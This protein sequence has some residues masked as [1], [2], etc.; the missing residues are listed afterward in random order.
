MHHYFFLVLISPVFLHGLL[1]YGHLLHGC[2]CQSRMISLLGTH[3][4]LSEEVRVADVPMFGPSLFK[5][6]HSS[7]ALLGP[8]DTFIDGRWKIFE[9]MEDGS[10]FAQRAYRV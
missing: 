10:Q 7:I 1:A 3:G 8:I 2:P 4:I 9:E 5:T 6:I